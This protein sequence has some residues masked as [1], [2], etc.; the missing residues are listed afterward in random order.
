[1][2]GGRLLGHPE[3]LEDTGPLLGRRRRQLLVP[4]VFSRLWCLP[5]LGEVVPFELDV[6][7]AGG[8]GDPGSDQ[9]GP[10]R[11]HPDHE[12]AAPIVPDEIEPGHPGAR[13]VPRASRRTPPSSL[14][15][16]PDGRCRTRGATMPPCQ[17]GPAQPTGRA[18]QR[19][20]R[21]LHGR[22]RRPWPHTVTA[23]ERSHEAAP[24][25]APPRRRRRTPPHREQ[26]AT[27]PMLACPTQNDPLWAAAVERFVERRAG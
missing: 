7:D 25:A 4:E 9:L 22:R 14:R 8:V 18:K 24:S 10:G 3:H 6:A 13:A 2:P 19:G 26:T 16:R 15:N 5:D 1:M 21:A 27:T 11:D 20:S 17:G 23:E 12:P